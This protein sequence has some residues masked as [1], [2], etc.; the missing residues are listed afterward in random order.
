MNEVKLVDLNKLFLEEYNKIINTSNNVLGAHNVNQSY[1]F[2]ESDKWPK[3][4]WHPN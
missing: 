3:G 1:F 4:E 2:D